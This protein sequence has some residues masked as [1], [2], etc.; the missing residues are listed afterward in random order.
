MGN[1][2]IGGGVER[3]I[4]YIVRQLLFLLRFYYEKIS[5]VVIKF[6]I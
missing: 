5:P 4:I 6:W 2:T 3:S 1:I